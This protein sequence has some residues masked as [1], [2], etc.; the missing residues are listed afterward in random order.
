MASGI[1][2]RVGEFESIQCYGYLYDIFY[3]QV[4]V[5]YFFIY[6]YSSELKLCLE[7]NFEEIYF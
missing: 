1:F 5:F 7:L 6:I 4:V 2:L 3:L